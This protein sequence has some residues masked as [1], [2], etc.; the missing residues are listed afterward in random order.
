MKVITSDEIS[1]RLNTSYT[2]KWFD[3][4]SFNVI[5]SED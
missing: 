3:L 5:K 4:A 1:G 2:L